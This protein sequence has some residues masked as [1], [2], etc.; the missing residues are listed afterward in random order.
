MR[1]FSIITQF[2][3]FLRCFFPIVPQKALFRAMTFL[4]MIL[5]IFSCRNLLMIGTKFDTQRVSW[6]VNLWF[7]STKDPFQDNLLKLVW[8]FNRRFGW[9]IPHESGIFLLVL[10]VYAIKLCQV[11]IWARLHRLFMLF[12]V[13]HIAWNVCSKGSTIIV[14]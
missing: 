10:L 7:S 11:I 6:C 12:D 2:S 9:I 14:V 13:I 4:L 1:F 5:I 8:W 3:Y